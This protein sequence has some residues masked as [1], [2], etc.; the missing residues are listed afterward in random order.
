[1]VS[2]GFNC[3][4]CIYAFRKR[5]VKGVPYIKKPP[6]V[7]GAG[8]L[9]SK[10]TGGLLFVFYNPSVSLTLNTSLCTR[11]AAGGCVHPPLP[12]LSQ[13]TVGANCVRPH[14]AADRS[15]EKQCTFYGG[16]P[17]PFRR[18]KRL[19]LLGQAFFTNLFICYRFCLQRR[20]VWEFAPCGP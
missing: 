1:M 8:F 5:N 3:R 2:R 19:D 18:K 20:I 14:T 17:F 6:C 15:Y 4:E 16:G 11:E 10:K 13:V 9:Q 12:I 7:K